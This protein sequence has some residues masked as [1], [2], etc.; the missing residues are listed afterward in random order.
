MGRALKIQKN[1]VG[2]GTTV[3]GSN[4][5]VTTYNQT[6]LADAGYPNFGSLTDPV[7]NSPTQTLDAA[8]F[9]GVV[10]GSN[11]AVTSGTFPVV[12]ITANVNGQEGSAHIITQKGT[13]KYLVSGENTVNAGSFTPNFSYQIK[14]LGKLLDVAT[15]NEVDKYYGIKTTA[16]K[17]KTTSNKFNA[18]CDIVE[19]EPESDNF[20]I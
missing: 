12:A 2:A 5:V 7:Y 6:I 17:G 4:P 11:T 9:L 20:I 1:N 18:D 19:S 16:E 14:A 3:S 10:G 13:Y 8:Q 15:E